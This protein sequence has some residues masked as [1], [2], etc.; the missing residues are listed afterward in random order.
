MGAH[1]D[2]ARRRL[3]QRRCGGGRRLLR[4]D[5]GDAG[6]GR[7]AP[8]APSRTSGGARPT[9]AAGPAG[10]CRPRPE[11]ASTANPRTT[12]A[13]L[14]RAWS[15]S[16]SAAFGALFAPDAAYTDVATGHTHRGRAAITT[17]HR[18]TR[19]AIPDLRAEVE[20]GFATDDGR[21]CATLLWT[22]TP[23]ADAP[24]PPFR[25][26]V[27][28]VLTLAADGSIT[29]CADYYDL[30]GLTGQGYAIVPRRSPES[31]G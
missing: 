13:R 15:V 1:P 21:A 23:A 24:G 30:L 29:R 18:D 6:V 14:A 16:D 8:P 9:H 2:G 11:E 25:V 7:P 19:V 27:A 26:R 5:G 4:R 17:W 12:A 3:A 28:T 20:D 31:R 22:G 10:T